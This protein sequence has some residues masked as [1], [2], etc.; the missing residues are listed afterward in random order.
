MSNYQNPEKNEYS[1]YTDTIEFFMVAKGFKITT[2]SADYH[3]YEKSGTEVK[4]PK[5]EKL[6][7]AQLIALLQETGLN[8]PDFE[9][10]VKNNSPSK[11]IKDFIKDAVNTPPF[12]K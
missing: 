3:Y 12:K 4:V 6:S 7:K 8:L 2:I 1:I 10:F 9:T 11:V 5:Q